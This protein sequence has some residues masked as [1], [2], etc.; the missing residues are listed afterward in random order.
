MEFNVSPEHAL[1]VLFGIYEFVLFSPELLRL[2]SPHAH[3]PYIRYPERINYFD[4]IRVFVSFVEFNELKL[5][6]HI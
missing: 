2:R 3:G 6:V 5:S 4:A 1:T